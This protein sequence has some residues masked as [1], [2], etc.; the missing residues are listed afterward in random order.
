MRS[1]FTLTPPALKY[2]AV[3]VLLVLAI[4]AAVVHYYRES[5]VRT[6]VN[7][8]LRGL[9]M[10]ATE[11]SVQSIGARTVRLSQLTLEQGGGTRYEIFDLAYPVSDA[12]ARRIE[13]GRLLMT[14]ADTD[15]VPAPLALLLGT[16]LELPGSVPNTEVII[17]QLATPGFPPAHDV[18]WRTKGKRQQLEL[19]LRMPASDATNE[20]GVTVDVDRIDD[21]VHRAVVKATASDHAD[22]FILRLDLH[23]HDGGVAITGDVTFSAAPWAS[24]LESAGVL[25]PGTVALDAELAGPVTIELGADGPASAHA[26]AS[27]SLADDVT[28]KYRATEDFDLRLSATASAPVVASVAYPSF[29]WTARV[30]EVDAEA[31]TE[32]IPAVPMRLRE[33]DCRAGIL[34]TVQVSVDTGPVEIGAIEVADAKLAAPLTIFIGASGAEGSSVAG[35]AVEGLVKEE[36]IA[37]ERARIAIAPDASLMMNGVEL[38]AVSIASIA[39]TRLERAHLVIDDGGWRIDADRLDLRVDAATDREGLLAS[40]PVRLATL[41]VRDGGAAADAEVTIEPRAATLSWGGTGIVVPG[42]A[43]NLALRDGRI[44]AALEL[45]DGDALSAR[46]DAAHDLTKATGTVAVRDAKLRFD[47]GATGHLSRRLVQWPYAWDVVAGTW[48]AE[49]DLDWETGADGTQYAGTLTQRADELA[50]RYNDTAFAGLNTTLTASLDSTAGFS[51]APT[52][53]DIALIDVGLPLERIT[54]KVAPDIDNQVVQVDDL[55][56]STLGGQI[57][58]DPFR[59]GL[60]EPRNDI[61]LRPRS[62]QLPFI[63]KLVDFGDIELTGSISGVIPVSIDDMQLTITNGRLE[64]DPPGGVIRY[65]PG[66]ELVESGTSTSPLDLVSVA[67]ANFQFDS[68]TSDVNYNEAGDLLLQM[69]LSGINP[70]MDNKQPVILNLGID[71]NIPQLLRSLRATRSI[72]EI[73]ARKTA[74]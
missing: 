57:V 64:S 3:V 39:T 46:V 53:L 24:V 66:V 17:G 49:L 18:A 54:A 61:T 4:A 58:A 74:N 19:A 12:D 27:L 25:S 7:A 69:K 45:A 16:L 37:G 20:V 73:L 67:L 6:A 42:I 34:C 71:N 52:V 29:E 9:D 2:T 59:F 40:G 51:A 22:A 8:A 44:S 38:P 65:R 15:A 1:V 32:S 28:A 31:A 33:L 43:G 5:L 35:S 11:L 41:R 23:T 36:S 14:P 26:S 60:K 62:I 70:D 56:L 63:M 47:I 50:G 13:I 68:L 21:A 55:S 30:A 72:E 48:S 10:R